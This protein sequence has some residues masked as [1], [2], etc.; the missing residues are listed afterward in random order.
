MIHE[1]TR[2]YGR[3]NGLASVAVAAV[4]VVVVFCM[5]YRVTVQLT[6][7]RYLHQERF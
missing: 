5:Y 6:I 2:Y 4:V 1:D 7:Q 3:R